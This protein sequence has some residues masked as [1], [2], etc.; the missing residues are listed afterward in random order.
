VKHNSLPSLHT[1]GVKFFKDIVYE[2]VKHDVVGAMIALITNEREGHVVDRALIKSCVEIFETMGE[3]KE[4][5][6]EDFEEALLVDT[7][8]YYARK[9]QVR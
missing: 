7:R 6:K 5:Y 3:S 2:S 9:S 1:S 4:C 8:E